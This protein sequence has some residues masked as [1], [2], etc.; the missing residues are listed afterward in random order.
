MKTI[1]INRDISWLSF[2]A[3]VLQE[4]ADKT[5][6]IIERI[7][8]LGIFSNNLDE[9]FRVRVG[10][11]KRMI[12]LGKD[13]KSYIGENPLKVLRK[14]QTIVVN[15]QK[16]FDR[17]YAE[18]LIELKKK[19]IFIVDEK[20]LTKSQGLFV[21]NYFREKV[22]PLLVPIM[23]Q[24]T[25]RIPS[26]R[27]KSIYLAVKLSHKLKNKD[28][29]YALI[30]VP[31]DV[32]RF[33]QLPEEDKK[34]GT[35]IILL[36]DVIRFCL[37]DIFFVFN[38]DTYGAYTVKLTRDAE[39]DIDSD[40]SKS[41][42]E[43]ISR[44]LKQRKIGEPVRLVYDHQIPH[45]MLDFFI[46]CMKI[47]KSQALLPGGRYHNF[48]DFMQFPSVGGV[49][50]KSMPLAIMEHPKLKGNKSMFDVLRKED[51]LLTF[52]YQSF[53][54]II[55]FLREAAI[56]PA[57][58]SIKITLYRVAKNSKIINALV[59]AIQNGKA[60]TVVVELQARFDEQANLNLANKLQD[61][62]AT[63]IYGVQG[64]KV[65]SKLIYISR[66]EGN[67]NVA[68]AHVG[69]GNFNESTAKVYS[70]FSLL[71]SDSR[72]TSEVE[73]V[74]HFFKNNYKTG[75]YKNLLVAP[76][77]MRN[78]L[79][80]LIQ[81]EIKNAKANKPALIQLKLNSLTDEEL[82]KK[83]YAASNAGVK[84]QLIIRG[85]CS[86][87]PGIK[88]MSENIEAISLVDQFLEHARSMVFYNGGKELV[89]IS[90]ADW[91]IR[92]LDFRTEVACPIYNTELQKEIKRIFELQ[93]NGSTKVRILNE[94]Q[95]NPYRQAPDG[96]KRRAQMEI[97]NYFKQKK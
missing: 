73:K 51:I 37:E 86:L 96:I 63:L 76:F 91:M 17:I 74:F 42:T 44:S 5:L 59:N 1:L 83:L 58:T 40:L 23:I 29:R 53:D 49:E 36:D 16:E 7:K 20:S 87:V 71:T 66:K 65:H 33:V 92:N 19:N 88:G 81:N 21:K 24:H 60:V 14:I 48:K 95:D 80:K 55:D 26:L 82:I 8:F 64:L 15:Q 30:Q 52:P 67:K 89:Y 61:E 9:F 35:F 4:A 93:W 90:S 79:L 31:D 75:T 77:F 38:Y 34:K 28:S 22:R 12:N 54:H 70:D 27:D 45:D 25:A 78:K 85:I 11:Y 62:G 50:L 41:I 2:N 69:T 3:R 6:P 46:K 39:L 13:A 72:I 68:Y 10:T 32:P 94:K 47:D 84:I 43:K 97:Y 57:V 18:I 56:D